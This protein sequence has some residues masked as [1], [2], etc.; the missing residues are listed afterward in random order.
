MAEDFIDY[1]ETVGWIVGRKQMKSWPH[2]V[3]RWV[4]TT[5]QRKQQAWRKQAY[6]NYKQGEVSKPEV[7]RDSD[8]L[9]ARERE[10]KR[11]QTND[12]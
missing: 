7:V 1:Y 12:S 4:R 2:A 8:G 5:Y 9:T 6:S 11:R 10:L 3:K